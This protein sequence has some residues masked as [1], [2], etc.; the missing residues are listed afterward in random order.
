MKMTKPMYCKLC[1][2]KYRK[3]M[4]HCGHVWISKDDIGKYRQDYEEK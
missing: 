4:E 2:K 3:G 1:G